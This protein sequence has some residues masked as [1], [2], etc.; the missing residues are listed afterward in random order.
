[1]LLLTSVD[2]R[3]LKN[4]GLK[5]PNWS[6]SVHNDGQVCGSVKTAVKVVSSILMKLKTTMVL[7]LLLQFYKFCPRASS[8]L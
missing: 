8:L 3:V 6:V 7:L 4:E 5:A 2:F 1:M